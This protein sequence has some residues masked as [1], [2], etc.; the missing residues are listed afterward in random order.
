ML[1]LSLYRNVSCTLFLMFQTWN[2]IGIMPIIQ[3]P[4]CC[5]ATSQLSDKPQ[6]LSLTPLQAGKLDYLPETALWIHTASEVTWGFHNRSSFLFQQCRSARTQTS[7]FWVDSN[8]FL[9][10]IG[11]YA[12]RL[13]CKSWYYRMQCF[14]H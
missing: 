7:C 12:L 11:I 2:R 10:Y 13:L 4:K 14:Y 8:C 5:L 1:H 3:P 6:S 9:F